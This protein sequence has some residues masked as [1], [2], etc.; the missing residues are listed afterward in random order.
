MNLRKINIK[1]KKPFELSQRDIAVVKMLSLGNSSKGIS[2]A[3]NISNR[4]VESII[5]TLKHEFKCKNTPHLVGVF[6]RK[7]LIK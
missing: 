3:G 2:K 4:T 1:K 6:F 5:A 7:D